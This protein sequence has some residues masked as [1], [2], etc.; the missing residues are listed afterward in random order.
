MTVL[1]PGSLLRDICMVYSMAATW[2][3]FRVLAT[4]CMIS[5]CLVVSNSLR[6]HGLSL[7]R[8]FCP[9][10]FPGKNNGVGCH[11][12]LPGISLPQGLKPSLLCLLCWLADSL[13]LCH[14][15][16]DLQRQLYF[17]VLG[18]HRRT[19][20]VKETFHCYPHVKTAISR[21]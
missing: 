5:A 4:D 9:W 11:F 20:S 8:L 7:S 12:L 17:Q 3:D 1:F 14:L 10:K 21:I 18:R 16:D 6:L 19:V 15:G 2:I 13:R